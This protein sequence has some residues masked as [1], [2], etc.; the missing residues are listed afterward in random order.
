M[1]VECEALLDSRATVTT[2]PVAGSTYGLTKRNVDRPENLKGS[3]KED[4][5][6]V[7][8]GAQEILEDGGFNNGKRKCNTSKYLGSRIKVQ[9]VQETESNENRPQENMKTEKGGN[10]DRK[11]D[12]PSSLPECRWKRFQVYLRWA[13]HQYPNVKVSL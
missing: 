3:V 9:K 10:P 7:E 12:P 11:E 5:D 2:N 4:I 1:D 6:L 13:L 8:H